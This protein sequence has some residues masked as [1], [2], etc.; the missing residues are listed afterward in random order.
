MKT[1]IIKY[2]SN[3]YVLDK[4]NFILYI[5]QY[6]FLK[7]KNNLNKISKIIVDYDWIIFWFIHLIAQSQN[8][9]DR[10]FDFSSD[11]L[12]YTIFN[13]TVIFF[14]WQLDRTNSFSLRESEY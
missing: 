1:V 14:F 7:Y 2:L 8:S 12:I 10:S 4:F 11:K 5:I 9:S 3:T 6:K 13:S